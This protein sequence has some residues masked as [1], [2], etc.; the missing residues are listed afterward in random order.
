MAQNKANGEDESAEESAI[1]PQYQPIYEFDEDAGPAYTTG[2]VVD[3]VPR[4]DQITALK[5]I[6]GDGPVEPDSWFQGYNGGSLPVLDGVPITTI[7]HST[8]IDSH[9]EGVET[10]SRYAVDDSLGPVE[11]LKAFAHPG[12]TSKIK[13]NERVEGAD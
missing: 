11:L 4:D 5:S 12:N 1:D 6:A 3:K 9:S 13:V 2:E 8:L 7:E 10:S